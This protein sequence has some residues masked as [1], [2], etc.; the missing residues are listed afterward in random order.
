MHNEGE[1]VNSPTLLK[2]MI[3][4]HFDI[5]SLY[6]WKTLGE[7]LF[8]F[9]TNFN[10]EPA[11]EPGFKDHGVKFLTYEDLWEAVYWGEG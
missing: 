3:F 9:D 11:Y 7:K 5:V 8:I 2:K 1:C 10:I 4:S 6:G